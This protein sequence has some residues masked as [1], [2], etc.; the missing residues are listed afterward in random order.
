MIKC[1]FF[2]TKKKADNKKEEI[3]NLIISIEP[4]QIYMAGDLTDPFKINRRCF[5]ALVSV[6]DQV[7]KQNN[8]YHTCEILCYRG[9]FL[10]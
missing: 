3:K 8:L 1:I 2:W 4:N 9:G 10:E 6:F 7:D 5:D